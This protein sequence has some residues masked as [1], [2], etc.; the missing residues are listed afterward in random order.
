MASRDGVIEGILADLGAPGM[1]ERH[2]KLKAKNDPWTRSEIRRLT[3]Q[4]KR[5]QAQIR[6]KGAAA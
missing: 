1:R 5:I 6:K 2:L 3:A 4:L